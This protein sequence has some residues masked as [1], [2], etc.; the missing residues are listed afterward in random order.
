LSRLILTFLKGNRKEGRGDK[1][2]KLS[3]LSL[4]SLL[5]SHEKDLRGLYG[6]MK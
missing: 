1:N 2:V 5:S 6:D 4:L 3:L